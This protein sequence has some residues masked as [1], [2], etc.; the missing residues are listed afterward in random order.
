MQKRAPSQ[1]QSFL[2]VGDGQSARSQTALLAKSLAVDLE[3]PSVDI[4][5]ISPPKDHVTIDQ[6]RELKNHIFQKPIHLGY[7]FI[8]IEHA[9]KMTLAAQN[10]LLKILEEPPSGAII[11]LEAKDKSL[12]LPTINSRVITLQSPAGKIQVKGGKTSILVTEN[13]PKALEKLAQIE[14]PIDWLDREIVLLY[15][16]LL[17]Q[18]RIFPPNTESGSKKSQISIQKIVHFIKECARTKEMIEANVNSRFA[19]ANLIFSIHLYPN[20]SPQV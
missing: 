3:T 1:F 6:V 12:L 13:I 9:E 8:I 5:R 10:A 2:I 4:F 16:L 18:T 7:K 19:L 17:A 14:D 11:V 20:Q 15:K